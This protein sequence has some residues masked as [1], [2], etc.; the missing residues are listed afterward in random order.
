MNLSITFDISPP[1]LRLS[2]RFAKMFS[3]NDKNKS[4]LTPPVTG[5]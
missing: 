4:V 1:K 5:N 3:H 2:G